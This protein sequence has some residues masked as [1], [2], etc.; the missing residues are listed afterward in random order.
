[1]FI[2]KIPFFTSYPIS[3]VKFLVFIVS[4]PSIIWDLGSKDKSHKSRKTSHFVLCKFKEVRGE[5]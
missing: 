5:S 1:M 4:D 2:L 3:S